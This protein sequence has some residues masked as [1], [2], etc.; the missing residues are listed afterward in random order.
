MAMGFGLYCMRRYIARMLHQSAGMRLDGYR[1]VVYGREES[2]G[3]KTPRC[4]YA[5]KLAPIDTTQYR[6]YRQ[7]LCMYLE[8]WMDD[9]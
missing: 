8:D 7:Y 3:L 2:R 4:L 9:L 6:Q 5:E 1:H